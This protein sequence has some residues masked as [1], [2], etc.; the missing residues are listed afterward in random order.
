MISSKVNTTVL[1]VEPL[2]ARKA[3]AGKL[4]RHPK[5]VRWVS[6]E[7]GHGMSALANE[8]ADILELTKENRFHLEDD[9]KFS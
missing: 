2:P 6:A 1:S 3:V 7:K 4:G 8:I 9:L 5:D